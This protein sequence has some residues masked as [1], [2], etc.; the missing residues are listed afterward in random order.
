MALGNPEIRRR[1][2]DLETQALMDDSRVREIDKVVRESWSELAAICIRVRD[3]KLWEL[4]PIEFHS[5]DDWLLS[6]APVCRATIYRGMGVL[7]VLA[8][9]LEPADIAQMEIGNASILAYEVSSSNVRRDPEVLA[10][11]KG[12]RYSKALRDVVKRK[13]PSQHMEDVHVEKIVFTASQWD[14]VER[15]YEAYRVGDPSA[16]LA[17]FI[18][19]LVTC[20]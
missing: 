20:A 7:S 6:A 19:W 5:F 13:F 17:V 15:A 1:S 10:A 14:V 18:E 8:K 4:L 2:V 16:T 3:S 12:A 9:D 11:A